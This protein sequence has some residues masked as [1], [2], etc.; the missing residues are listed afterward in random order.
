MR[1]MTFSILFII[2]F[3]GVVL[4]KDLRVTLDTPSLTYRDQ[5][6]GITIDDKLQ[7]T[8]KNDFDIKVNFV[9]P[10]DI[11]LEWQG[12]SEV[13]LR[14]GET[15]YLPFKVTV[16]KSGTYSSI[17]TVE[18]STEDPE[19]SPQKFSLG[20]ILNFVDIVEASVTAPHAILDA[21]VIKLANETVTGDTESKQFDNTTGPYILYSLI[22]VLIGIAG[23]MYFKS[24][25]DEKQGGIN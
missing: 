9:K 4:A 19:V 5:A 6:V 13:Y 17:V 1:I 21:E 14:A 16:G 7:V 20:A 25:K 2:L 3:S 11:L 10:T 15:T 18:F 24:K 12:P 23:Y 22:I 8:N